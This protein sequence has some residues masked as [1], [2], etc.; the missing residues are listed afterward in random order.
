MDPTDAVHMCGWKTKLLEPEQRV[1][2]VAKSVYHSSNR[3]AYLAELFGIKEPQPVRLQQLPEERIVMMQRVREKLK[4]RKVKEAAVEAKRQALHNE[5][6]A[7]LVDHRIPS[8]SVL[9]EI[10]RTLFRNP[11]TDQINARAQCS[12]EQVSSK[13]TE[14]K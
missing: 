8:A 7:Q 6:K 11:H 9:S 10:D 3:A 13:Y 12:F 5:V 1:K 14:Y 2:R 4:E